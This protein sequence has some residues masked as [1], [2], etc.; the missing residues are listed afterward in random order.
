[1]NERLRQK[2]D[3]VLIEQGAEGKARLSKAVKRSERTFERWLRQ[4]IPTQHDAYKLALACG[5][6]RNQAL[7]L[8]CEEP[9]AVRETA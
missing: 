7:A 4:G 2:I 8:A 6:T 1:M 5:C 9:E 3:R